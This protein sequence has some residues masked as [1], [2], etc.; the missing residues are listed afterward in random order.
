MST[1]LLRK[2]PTIAF[3]DDI[4]VLHDR[5][6]VP[7]EKLIQVLDRVEERTQQVVLQETP[8]FSPMKEAE[9]LRLAREEAMAT[10]VEKFAPALTAS[11]QQQMEDMVSAAV[12]SAYH[13]LR[14]DL[15]RQLNA[16][17]VQS[18]R[19]ELTRVMKEAEEKQFQR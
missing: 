14:S 2:E 9:R 8:D 5:V 17:I 13:H 3:K 19:E 10:L 1:E 6:N 12:T 16:L 11:M 4:P 7:W 15:T 18:V